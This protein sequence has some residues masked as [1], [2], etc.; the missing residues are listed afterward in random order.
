MSD[1]YTP[2]RRCTVRDVTLR[3]PL[4][5]INHTR[6]SV[7]L[8]VR[9]GAHVN[10]AAVERHAHIIATWREARRHTYEAVARVL[11][12]AVV[13]YGNISARVLNIEFIWRY[14]VIDIAHCQ[15]FYK[16][17]VYI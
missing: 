6:L 11:P 1:R 9:R 2:R 17:F 15:S 8:P 13:K 14:S 3:L 10:P 16:R 7:T 4:S 5:A 12:P